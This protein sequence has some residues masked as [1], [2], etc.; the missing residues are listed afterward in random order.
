MNVY[1]TIAAYQV[2][3]GD[4]IL[5]NGVDPVEVKTMVESGEAIMVKG[6]SHSTGDTV[7]YLLDPDTEVSLWA[8]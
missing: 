5:V 2:E 1:D 7:V 4:Q 8:L 6:Y 3:A